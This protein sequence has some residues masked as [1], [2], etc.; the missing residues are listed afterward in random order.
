MS[1][2]TAPIPASALTIA[3]G[4]TLV[5]RVVLEPPF[6]TWPVTLNN[7]QGGAFSYVAPATVLH[8]ASIGRYCSIGNNVAILSDHPVDRLTSSPVLYQALFGAPFETPEVAGFE[9][10]HH[11]VI[12]N[13][14]WIGAGVQIKTGVT[15]GDGAVVGAGSVVTRD[16]APYTIVG[17]VPARLIRPRFP[18]AVVARLQA[19]AWWR[20]N[21]LGLSLQDKTAEQALDIIEAAVNDGSLQPYA[22]VPMRVWKDPADGQIR[23]RLEPRQADQP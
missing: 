23:A 2:P 11:T 6:R 1:H 16:V 10:L 18:A 13:D 4:T 14:V 17:G 3:P 7:V 8:H 20:Y 9:R 12:G 5:G 21:V 15:I 19:L 22:P